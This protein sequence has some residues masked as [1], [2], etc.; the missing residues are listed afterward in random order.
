MSSDSYEFWGYPKIPLVRA[1]NAPYV[2][3][4]DCTFALG[5]RTTLL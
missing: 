4:G 2:A 5:R 3:F 1:V